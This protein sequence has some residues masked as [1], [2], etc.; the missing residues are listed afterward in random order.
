VPAEDGH[1]AALTPARTKALTGGGRLALEQG[2]LEEGTTFLEEGV[3]RLRE[4]G[5]A[6]TS[7][8]ALNNLGARSLLQGPIRASEASLER[9]PN[10]VVGGG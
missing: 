1:E 5:Q 10:A 6:Q 9:G 3:R 2:D 8:D 4:S 7:A